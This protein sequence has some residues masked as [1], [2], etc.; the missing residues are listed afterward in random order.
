MSLEVGYTEKEQALN[1]FCRFRTE[2]S[3]ARFSV[4]FT[5]KIRKKVSDYNVVSSCVSGS[6]VQSFTRIGG[7]E[8]VEKVFIRLVM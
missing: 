8:M 2:F 7:V 1:W 4:V 3:S 5:K 6:C